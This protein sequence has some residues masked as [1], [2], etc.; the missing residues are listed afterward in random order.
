MS[1]QNSFCAAVFMSQFFYPTPAYFP[2]N[3]VSTPMKVRIFLPGVQKNLTEKST[4][5]TFCDM[6]SVS[7]IL[8]LSANKETR[9]HLTFGY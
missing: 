8:C 1:N 5:A 9:V 4:G 2:L 6:H 7:H 3:P